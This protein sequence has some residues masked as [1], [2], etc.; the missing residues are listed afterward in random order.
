MFLFLIGEEG[1]KMPF[2]NQSQVKLSNRA[3]AST[4]T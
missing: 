1:K 4:E 2:F 3:M